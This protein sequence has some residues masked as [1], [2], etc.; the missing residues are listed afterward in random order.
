MHK[1]FGLLVLTLKYAYTAPSGTIWLQLPVP[2]DLQARYGG[3]KLIKQA[4][5]TKDITLA[6]RKVDALCRH[7]RAE[8]ESL[9]AAPESSP[10]AIAAHA[11]H[12]LKGYGLTPS[13]SSTQGQAQDAFYDYV[14]DKLHK[15]LGGDGEETE[16]HGDP[17]DYDYDGRSAYE[18]AQPTAGLS[19][20]EAVA[21]NPAVVKLVVA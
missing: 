18:K 6:A 1:A 3:R 8:W 11:V 14:Q 4:L 13:G 16:V 12:L 2:V 17:E 20:V 15:H 7:Y 9:R 5:K 10:A 19:P 21:Y